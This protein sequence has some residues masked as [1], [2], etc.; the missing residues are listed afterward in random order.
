MGVDVYLPIVKTHI[1]FR[2][3][4]NPDGGE[5]DIASVVVIAMMEPFLALC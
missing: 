4:I 1:N 5:E 2:L 3:D